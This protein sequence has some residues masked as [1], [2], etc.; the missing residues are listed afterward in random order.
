M[1]LK[2]DYANA[3][4]NSNYGNDSD[5]KVK[6]VRTMLTMTTMIMTVVI[7]VEMTKINMIFNFHTCLND[8]VY[9]ESP[10]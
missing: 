8:D 10:L 7:L 4:D 6:N 2:N 3:N 1:L 9:L 5:D